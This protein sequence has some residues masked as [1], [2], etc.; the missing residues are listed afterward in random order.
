MAVKPKKKRS[1]VKIAVVVLLLLAVAVLAIWGKGWLFTLMADHLPW[2]YDREVSQ[3]ER[4]KRDALV[5]EALQ[6]LG[7]QEGSAEHKAIV[8]LYNSHTPLAQGYEVQYDDNWCSTF[9]SAVAIAC[10]YTDF[11]P[12]ECGCQRHIGLLEEMGCWVEADDYVPLT[13]DLIFYSSKDK[14]FGD[15]TGWSDHIGIVVGTYGGYIRVIEGNYGDKVG[16]RVIKIGGFGIR[17]Y[18][19]PDYS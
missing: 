4:D 2:G 17:G 11:I 9:V 7:T 19:T 14:G 13:G 1:P 10:D 18:G 6:W 12:T 16:Y 15:C 3:E 5:E 8:D